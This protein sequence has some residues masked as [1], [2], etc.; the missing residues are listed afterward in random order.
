MF[1]KVS[2]IQEFV[3][4]HGDL[5]REHDFYLSVEAPTDDYYM[6][7]FIEDVNKYIV[8]LNDNLKE[9][10]QLRMS[11]FVNELNKTIQEGRYDA[12]I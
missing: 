8:I 3:E 7:F 12:E 9:T 5:L 11:E 10:M 4:K 6:A 1:N 2:N